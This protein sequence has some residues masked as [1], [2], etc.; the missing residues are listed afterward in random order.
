LAFGRNSGVNAIKQR[1][2]GAVIRVY[3]A[4]TDFAALAW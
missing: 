1:G 3:G 4:Y 2:S